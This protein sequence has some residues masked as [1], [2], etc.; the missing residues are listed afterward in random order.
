M[1]VQVL[2]SIGSFAGTV[3]QAVAAWVTLY[4][5][6]KKPAT[7]GSTDV[8]TT[9]NKS[10]AIWL[11]TLLIAGIV[12]T[13]IVGTALLTY[14][15]KPVVVE[16]SVPCPP[17]KSGAATTRGLESPAISGSGN[18]VNYGLPATKPDKKE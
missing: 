4:D 6:F 12:S 8:S 7:A 17:S 13:A 16:K 15:P 3:I 10:R 14:H 2:M 1:N 18:D 9:S 5:R 11:S